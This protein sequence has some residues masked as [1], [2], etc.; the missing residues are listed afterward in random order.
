M[1]FL[2]LRPDM[3]RYRLG[4]RPSRTWSS[5][6]ELIDALGQPQPQAEG[7]LMSADRDPRD[8]CQSDHAHTWPFL[9]KPFAFRAL[10]QV[11]DSLL[12]NRPADSISP[13]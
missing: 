8:P 10:Q 13:R 12:L 11:I 9:Q 4:T 5:G 3:K 6:V 2:K 7:I 1:S